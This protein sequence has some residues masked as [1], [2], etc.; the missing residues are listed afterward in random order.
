MKMHDAWLKPLAAAGLVLLIG[1]PGIAM[2]G[3]TQSALLQSYI[4]S[5]R[6]AGLLSGGEEP[7]NFSCRIQVT[8]GNQGKINYQGRCGVA[9]I[10]LAIYGTIHYNDGKNRYEGVMNSNTEFKGLA[11]GRPRGNTIVFD[12]RGQ[13]QREGNNLTI[14]SQ[15]SLK[16]DS[17]VV[18]FDVWIAESDIKLSTSVPFERK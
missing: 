17:I 8:D 11:I 3:P 6:G 2:A 1:F 16:K 7:E 14:N 10:N 4:G 12:F 9:G 5:W 15:M 13:E 18:D